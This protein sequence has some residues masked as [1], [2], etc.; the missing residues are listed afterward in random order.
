MERSIPKARGMDGLVNEQATVVPTI[1]FHQNNCK[2]IP[3]QFYLA[4]AT[5]IVYSP[6]TYRPESSRADRRRLPIVLGVNRPDA[7]L[8]TFFESRVEYFCDIL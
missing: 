2:W 8:F 4:Y 3:V 5:S 7:C 6:A 1:P